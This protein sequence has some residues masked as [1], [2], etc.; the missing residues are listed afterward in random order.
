MKT[1]KV[2]KRYQN[3]KLYDTEA[4]TYVTLDDITQMI[5]DGEDVKVI[6]NKTKRD[7]TAVTL[8]QIIFEEQKKQREILSLPSLKRIIQSGGEVDHRLRR[9]AN[10]ARDHRAPAGAEGAGTEDRRAHRAGQAPGRGRP[11]PDAATSWRPLRAGST[12]CSATWTAASAACGTASDRRP[13]RCRTGSGSWKPRSTSWKPSWRPSAPRRIERS[14]GR[15]RSDPTGPTRGRQRRPNRA[16]LFFYS[17]PTTRT[18]SRRRDSPAERTVR[19]RAAARTDSAQA[20][21]PARS[22]SSAV[23][24]RPSVRRNAPHPDLRRDP[25]R[26]PAPT[27][28]ARS[29]NDT[30]RPS[31]RRSPARRPAPSAP[32]TPGTDRLSV[33]GR[34]RSRGPVQNRVGD[35]LAASRIRGGS[36]RPADALSA[37]AG[38]IAR[39]DFAGGAESGDVDDVLRPGAAAPALVPPPPWD[40]PAPASPPGRHP[41]RPDPFRAV[42]LVGDD[43]SAD[44]RPSSPAGQPEPCP[45]LC[46]ASV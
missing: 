26:P 20:A 27:R 24:G 8:A 15:H 10:R 31:T 32:S 30:P 1:T 23:V 38:Q 36:R 4:S 34:R 40:H 2:I 7:L 25:H 18:A 33:L 29:P 46:A 17:S 21:P 35:V 43:G 9:E 22:T 39:R 12:S 19:P 13:D 5:R 28:A 44:R 16:A 11:P 42:E 45:Q 41:Q 3:R 6:D 14:R 37:S